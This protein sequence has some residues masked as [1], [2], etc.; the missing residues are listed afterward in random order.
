MGSPDASP[1]NEP[2]LPERPSIAQRRG[3]ATQLSIATVTAK[4]RSKASDPAAASNIAGVA[5]AKNST[6][7]G[8]ETMGKQEGIR[9]H[10]ADSAK[11]LRKEKA[12]RSLA[13]STPDRKSVKSMSSDSFDQGDS[14]LEPPPF[15]S[16]PSVNLRRQSQPVVE[17]TPSMPRI[18]SNSVAGG[19]IRMYESLSGDLGEFRLSNTDAAPSLSI[20]SRAESV[21]AIGGEPTNS[22][23]VN[24][25]AQDDQRGRARTISSPAG[26]NRIRTKDLEENPGLYTMLVYREEQDRSQGYTRETN[27]ILDFIDIIE[28]ENI[29]FNPSP[30]DLRPD[31][32]FSHLPNTDVSTQ[33]ASCNASIRSA[34]SPRPTNPYI[35]SLRRILVAFSYYSWPHPD[36]TR[37]PP[38]S[39]TYRIGYCQSLNFIAGLLLLIDA[40]TS[41]AGGASGAS[42]DGG[43]SFGSGDEDTALK[44]EERTFWLLV[45]IVEK[46]LPPETYGASLEGAQVA[47][48]V[49][50]TWLLGERGVRF[51]VGR[52]AKWVSSLESDGFGSVNTASSSGNVRRIGSTSGRR[53]KSRSRGGGMPPLSMV[54]TSWFMT[55]FVNVLP[56]ET[57]LR[58]WDNFFFQGEKVLMRVT[59]TL[60][61]IHEEQVLACSDPTEAWKVVK[62]IPPRMIDCHRLMEICFK[63][64]LSLNP[65]EHESSSHGSISRG[66]SLS[67]LSL[68]NHDDSD[69]DVDGNPSPMILN[70]PLRGYNE[71]GLA[72]NEKRLAK[73]QR[74]GVGSVPS[75][76]IK[77]Y[78]DLALQERRERGGAN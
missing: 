35:R 34:T 20:I 30:A 11:H 23:L 76:L 3:S 6:A 27:K 36:E 31:G 67:S 75:K 2:A 45:A 58:V 28:R 41:G 32:S 57:V 46:L 66:G 15:A 48:E 47:Q 40:R 10:A 72:P 49:L 52:V 42:A 19:E 59:L 44:V 71:N 64:R 51:G 73:Y 16:P 54:T 4:L 8:P 39:C 5:A 13:A 12:D 56:V 74:R 65:F 14:A 70:D 68:A 25:I 18:R 7:Q 38:R 22:K 63:P 77:Y 37:A 50:W 21:G 62:S 33:P 55:L 43:M 78:R 69:D 24:V 9:S 29:H 60:I 61:K 17:S 1:T 53:G 26:L